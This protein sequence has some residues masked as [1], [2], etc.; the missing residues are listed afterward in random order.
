MYIWNQNTVMNSDTHMI[1]K[2]SLERVK[3]ELNIATAISWIKYF[4]R[5][6][7]DFSIKIQT[8]S[9]CTGGFRLLEWSTGS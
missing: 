8:V 4:K 5:S 7:R 9:K 3:L 6:R 1:Y 2:P